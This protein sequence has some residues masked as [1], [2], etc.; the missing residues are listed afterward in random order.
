[1]SRRRSGGGNSPNGDNRAA[2]NGQP[3]TTRSRRRKNSGQPTAKAV[4]AFWGSASDLP[5]HDRD[6]KLTNDP[7]ALVRS[8]GRPPL[9]GHETIA[10][11]YFEA[12]YARTVTLAGAL[13][14]AGDLIDPEE[15]LG[16]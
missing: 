15:L 11:H 13:A 7:S 8:L 1:M 5:T 4:R 6:L 3:K 14:A 12:I 9:N 2:G 10:E 16:E